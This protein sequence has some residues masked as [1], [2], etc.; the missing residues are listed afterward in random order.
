MQAEA[1]ELVKNIVLHEADSTANSIL[2][3]GVIAGTAYETGRV[4]VSLTRDTVDAARGV[5]MDTKT[6]VANGAAHKDM[7]MGP[8]HAS[9]H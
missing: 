2:E 8:N 4:A 7:C 9:F 6:A 1:A 5:A 3:H